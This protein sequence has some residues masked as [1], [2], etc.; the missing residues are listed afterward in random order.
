[1]SP[2]HLAI[3]LRWPIIRCHFFSIPNS[4][5]LPIFTRPPDSCYSLTHNQRSIQVTTNN[6]NNNNRHVL[7]NHQFADHKTATI[8]G[9]SSFIM[10]YSSVYTSIIVL[11]FN[12]SSMYL[13]CTRAGHCFSTRHTFLIATQFTVFFASNNNRSN[14]YTATNASPTVSSSLKSL[15]FSDRLHSGRV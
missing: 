5:T 6:N 14:Q 9:V 2:G 8:H 15:G 7:I 3:T 4:Q 11:Q 10:Q 12:C 13:S 1:M